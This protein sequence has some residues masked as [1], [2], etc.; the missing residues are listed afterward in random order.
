[1]QMTL[2]VVLPLLGLSSFFAVAAPAPAGIT[3]GEGTRRQE[4]KQQSSS[5]HKSNYG[6]L[7]SNSSHATWNNSD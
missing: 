1:M 4:H 5:G 7:I 2:P 3:G 6:W